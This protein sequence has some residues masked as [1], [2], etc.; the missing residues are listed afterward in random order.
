MIEHYIW[1]SLRR[2]K[3]WGVKCRSTRL[4]I[5]YNEF[6]DVSH[7][8]RFLITCKGHI[9]SLH[10]RTFYSFTMQAPQVCHK[11]ENLDEVTDDIISNE[12]FLSCTWSVVSFNILSMDEY[13]I[14]TL[15]T[16]YL[17]LPLLNAIVDYEESPI[18]RTDFHAILSGFNYILAVG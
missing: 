4:H 1:S 3:L 2:R 12:P 17:R 9:G 15:F 10:L 6:N 14:K 8:T 18:S 13:A 7:K 5:T 11:D 16:F